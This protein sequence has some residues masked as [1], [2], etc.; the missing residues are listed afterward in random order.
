R[1][2]LPDPHEWLGSDPQKPAAIPRTTCSSSP[3]WFARHNPGCVAYQL[4]DRAWQPESNDHDEGRQRDNRILLPRIWRRGRQPRIG[5][6][7]QPGDM[8]QEPGENNGQQT[9]KNDRRPI[10]SAVETRTK[11]RKLALEHAEGR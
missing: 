9:D 6:Q 2:H 10:L 1:S 11:Y 7:Y 3:S 8:R 4:V 5:T